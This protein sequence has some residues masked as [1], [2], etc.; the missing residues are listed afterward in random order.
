MSRNSPALTGAPAESLLALSG[1]GQRLRAHRVQ[2]GQ[3]V[4]QMAQRLLCS[5]ATYRAL[6]SGKPGT[7]LG[8]LAHALWLLGQLDT[9]GH[10]APL[11]AGFAAAAAGKRVRRKAGEPAAGSITERER[12]F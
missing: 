1:L 8:I 3:T 7:S 11:D 2:R 6:E 5:P 10:V 4:Q 9:L 12:D